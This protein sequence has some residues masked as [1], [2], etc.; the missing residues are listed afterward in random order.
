MACVGGTASAAR[1]KRPKS[2]AQRGD[3][4]ELQH[5]WKRLG[6]PSGYDAPGEQEL[7]DLASNHNQKRG[8]RQKKRRLKA[9]WQLLELWG[10][11]PEGV[12]RSQ[13]DLGR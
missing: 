6:R 8:E 13:R 11:L 4:T 1:L 10:H 3:D 7:K 12:V 2:S 9:N 5:A